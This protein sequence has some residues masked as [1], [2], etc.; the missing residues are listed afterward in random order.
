MPVGRV[1]GD[2]WWVHITE[3]LNQALEHPNEA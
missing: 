3:A 1:L 2:G